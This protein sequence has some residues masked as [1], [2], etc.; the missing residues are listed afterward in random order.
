VTPSFGA[1]RERLGMGDT[2][3]SFGGAVKREQSF[4]TARARGLADRLLVPNV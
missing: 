3:P 1:G 2:L 4:S